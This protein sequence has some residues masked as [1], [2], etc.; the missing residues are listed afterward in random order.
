MKV[1]LVVAVLSA[2]FVVL[3]MLP[4]E[5]STPNVSDKVNQNDVSDQAVNEPSTTVSELEIQ[6]Y[7]DEELKNLYNSLNFP[8]TTPIL[9]RPYITGDKSIDQRIQNLAETRGYQLREVPNLTLSTFDD[10]LIQDKALSDWLKLTE[11]ASSEGITI[12]IRSAYRSIEQQREL[13]LGELNKLDLKSGFNEKVNNILAVVAPPGY[14]R[15]HNGYTLDLFSPDYS[16]FEYS[17][18]YQWLIKDNYE[19]AKEFGFIPSYPKNATNQGPNPE[20]WEFV[21]SDKSTLSR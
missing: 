10:K 12:K 7:T 21:W 5:T 13:F 20:A 11:L 1:K 19:N 18:A 6:D 3:L 16:V 2:M 4:K 15:H 17:P 8:N 14:S 9:E